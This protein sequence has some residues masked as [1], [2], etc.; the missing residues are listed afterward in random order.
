MSRNSLAFSCRFRYYIRHP[1][2]FFREVKDNLENTHKRI[3]RGWAYSDVW[4]MEEWF[5]DVIPDMLDC[6][7]DRSH[8]YPGNEEFPTYESWAKYLRNIANDLRLCSEESADKMNEYYEDY[9]HS[10]ES[11]RLTEEDENGNLH[12][13]LRHTPEGEE[14]AK[15]YFA[16]CKEI[17][18]EQEAIREEAF[19]RLGRVLPLIWD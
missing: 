3:T 15:K 9:L 10:F 6:L 1:I 13:N 18:V 12:V 4:G 11:D 8:G 14:V 19:A 5:Y 17:E 7:A 2:K 16:R